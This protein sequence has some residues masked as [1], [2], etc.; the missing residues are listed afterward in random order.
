MWGNYGRILAEY[1]FLE[2]FKKKLMNK[3]ISIEGI[4][5]FRKN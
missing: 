3:Y 2:K 5:I 4:R 1:P